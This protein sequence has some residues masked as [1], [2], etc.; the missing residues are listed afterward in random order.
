MYFVY[1]IRCAD[2]SL[3]TGIATDVVLRFVE[4]REGKGARYTR[5]RGAVKVVYVEKYKNRSMA[6][7]RE[8]EIKGCTRAEKLTLIR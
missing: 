8:A 7:K 2:D 1:I 5:A 6:S 4:H 3:Y